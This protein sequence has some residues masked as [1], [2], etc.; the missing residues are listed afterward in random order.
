M[1]SLDAGVDAAAGLDAALEAL[2]LPHG[3]A[4]A[5][6]AVAGALVV[7]PAADSALLRGALLGSLGSLEEAAADAELRDALAHAG[8]A[9]AAGPHLRGA[10]A[11]S[12]SGGLCAPWSPLGGDDD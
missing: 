5:A 1:L 9:L 2:A 4:V 3:A 8:V 11:P 6:D 7:A 10:P 12:S